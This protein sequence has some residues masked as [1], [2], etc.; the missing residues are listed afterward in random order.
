MEATQHLTNEM[1]VADVRITFPMNAANRLYEEVKVILGN[2]KISSA[3]LVAVLLSLMQLVETYDDVKGLQKK[4]IILD[5]L[6]H[7]IEDQID[8]S[9]EATNLKLLIQLT[10]PS[11][12]DTFVSLDKKEI[13]IKLK[14]TCSKLFGCCGLV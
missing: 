5:T 4:A 14:K 6:N 12:I 3:N 11:V 13:S 1:K 10:L 7:I 8:D 9:Q 2:G